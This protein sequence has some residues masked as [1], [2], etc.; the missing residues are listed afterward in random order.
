[1]D[2]TRKPVVA[3]TFYFG[4]ADKLKEQI[5]NC[6]LTKEGKEL[7][8]K[9]GRKKIFGLIVPH[10]GYQYSGPAAA[11]G[12]KELAAS[13]KPD[14]IIILGPAHTGLGQLLQSG[15]EE[16]LKLRLELLKLTGSLEKN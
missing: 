16:L 6:F 1:M 15:R 5:E 12:Y 11:H 9:K 8:S 3:G 4:D 7:P 2:S 14:T 10:A 13:Q